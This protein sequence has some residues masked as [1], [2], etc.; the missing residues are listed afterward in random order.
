M[1]AVTTFVA[2]YLIAVMAVLC[3]LSILAYR[4]KAANGELEE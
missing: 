2:V 4:K 1:G 3:I